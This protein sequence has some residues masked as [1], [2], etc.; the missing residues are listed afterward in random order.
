MPEVEDV[1]G[2][3]P[4]SP[5]HLSRLGGGDLPR[6]KTD[7]GVQVPLPTSV[8]GI[9]AETYHFALSRSNG[10]VSS[11]TVTV[12]DGPYIVSLQWSNSNTCSTYGGAPC[13]PPP[14][15]PPPVPSASQMAHLVDAALAKIDQHLAA[16]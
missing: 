6:G 13:P 15:A 8:P 12:P 5:Q 9:S 4:G 3:A 1:A 7:G 2:L 11:A 14:T 16:T 10:W